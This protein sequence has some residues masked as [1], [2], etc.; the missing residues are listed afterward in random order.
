MLCSH[1]PRQVVHYYFVMIPRSLLSFQNVLHASGQ[2]RSF[3]IKFRKQ[4][5]VLNGN[6]CE[7]TLKR[8]KK[9]L[10]SE[11]WRIRHFHFLQTKDRYLADAKV[12]PRGERGEGLYVMNLIGF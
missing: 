5:N 10:C 8:F 12:C 11:S 4:L 7:R 9:H 6:G 1:V 3:L 2:H